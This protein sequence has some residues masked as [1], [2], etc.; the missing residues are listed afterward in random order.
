MARDHARQKYVAVRV[1]ISENFGNERNLSEILDHVKSRSQGHLTGSF[2]SLPLESFVTEGPNGKHLCTVF[3][4]AGPSIAQL[5]NVNISSHGPKK[6]TLTPRKA[7]RAA[8]QATQALAFLHSEIGVADGD[9]TSSNVLL[10]IE[11]FDH[12]SV[13]QLYDAIGSPKEYPLETYTGESLTASAPRTIVEP[14]DPLRLFQ[15]RKG[16]NI[17]IIDFGSSYRLN[18]P[19]AALGIPF[20]YQS[21]EIILNNTVGKEGDVWA[22]GCVIYEIR[23]C[24]KLFTN[25]F[26]TQFEVAESMRAVLGP[27]PQAMLDD[28]SAELAEPDEDMQHQLLS[29]RLSKLTKVEREPWYHKEDYAFMIRRSEGVVEKVWNYLMWAVTWRPWHKKGVEIPATV[30][31][32]EA[33]CF[34]D[35][36]TT[37]P[38]YDVKKRPTADQMLFHPWFSKVFG[39]PTQEEPPM[40]D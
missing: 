16:G 2:F 4:V 22:L 5:T 7:Q 27:F 33:D 32:D 8:L 30:A 17:K 39:K 12:L 15:Y 24:E 36:L 28:E 10:D 3:E 34:H 35:L 9:L 37:T 21:P 40:L 38:D 25:F 1:S 6:F 20:V 11:S 18:K 26:D 19:P 14:I 13:K 31:V 29:N 23:V